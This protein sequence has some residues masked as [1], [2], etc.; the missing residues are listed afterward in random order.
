MKKIVLLVSLILGALS[1]SA[2]Q[3]NWFGRTID[4]P[5]YVVVPPTVLFIAVVTIVAYRAIFSRTYVCPHCQTEIKPKW[6]DLS[7][8]IHMNGKRLAKCPHCGRKGFCAVK[9]K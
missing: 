4:A 1:L 6:T 2:C 7:L 3:V 9:K 8:C 5:W